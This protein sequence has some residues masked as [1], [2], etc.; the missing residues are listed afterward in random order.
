MNTELAHAELSKTPKFE[1]VQQAEQDRDEA[2]SELSAVS[3]AQ[4]VHQEEVAKASGQ[5]ELLNSN[6]GEAIAKRAM[7]QISEKELDKARDSLQAAQRTVAEGSLPAHY[8]K[9]KHGA[10]MQRLRAASQVID[11]LDR[12]SACKP[13]LLGE[14][15]SGNL[16][17]MRIHRQMKNLAKELGPDA[18][19]NLA[20]FM[21]EMKQI[22]P[23]EFWSNC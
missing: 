11:L 23:P 13:L 16:N 1:C 12:Y 17:F 22:R 9:A 8:F 20:T 3:C 18:Q 14:S 10:A 15:Y 5:I 2:Q 19:N 21:D 6:L 4:S 7:L